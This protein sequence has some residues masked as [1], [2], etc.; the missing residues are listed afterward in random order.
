MPLAGPYLAEG[1]FKPNAD[2]CI[3]QIAKQ[4][5]A[6]RQE[7]NESSQVHIKFKEY[8]RRTSGACKQNRWASL[9]YGVSHGAETQSVLF[10]AG[11]GRGPKQTSNSHKTTDYRYTQQSRHAC[12]KLSVCCALHNST[13]E[14]R[15]ASTPRWAAAKR[16]TARGVLCHARRLA[17][18]TQTSS[19]ICKAIIGREQRNHGASR[20]YKEE[21]RREKGKENKNNKYL[22]ITWS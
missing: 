3:P 6:V 13:T 21:F 15:Q 19:M 17:L 20:T 18:A 8:L 14:I 2:V 7:M 11:R 16:V 4:L 22:N 10:V 12:R 5:S 1:G 9:W